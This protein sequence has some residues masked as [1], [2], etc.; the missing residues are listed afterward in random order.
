[1][2]QR[3]MDHGGM[4]EMTLER[5]HALKALLEPE[6]IRMHGLRPSEIRQLDAGGLAFLLNRVFEPIDLDDPYQVGEDGSS[7][8]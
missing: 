8:N 5:S 1:M 2:T 6:S 7:L 3:I 4:L